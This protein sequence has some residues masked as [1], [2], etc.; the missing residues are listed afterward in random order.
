[1]RLVLPVGMRV[2]AA[3]WLVSP[4]P[5]QLSRK[6][7]TWCRVLGLDESSKSRHIV[8][9][10]SDLARLP[11]APECGVPEVTRGLYIKTTTD[12]W[13]RVT[14]AVNRSNRKAIFWYNGFVSQRVATELEVALYEQGYVPH[15]HWRLF[16]DRAIEVPS[17][18]SGDAGY[19][20]AIERIWLTKPEAPSEEE[21]LIARMTARSSRKQKAEAY[22][23]RMLASWTTACVRAEKRRAK[24]A[25]KVAYYDRKRKRE[26]EPLLHRKGIKE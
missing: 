18:F 10:E 9:A 20:P 22:A 8:R 13:M 24:W 17:P 14:T 5:N 3:V 11:D 1:M 26:Q 21:M 25:R 2:Y 15:A 23:R 12:A 6:R 4:E 16:D 19:E 7:F